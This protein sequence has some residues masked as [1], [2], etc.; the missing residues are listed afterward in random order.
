MYPQ[1]PVPPSRHSP[2]ASLACASPAARAHPG[3]PSSEVMGVR[4]R[5]PRSPL[6]GQRARGAP[7]VGGAQEKL[8]IRPTLP[9]GVGG[10]EPAHRACWSDRSWGAPPQDAP[11]LLRGK[12]GKRG[13]SLLS[14]C[15]WACFSMCP[16]PARGQQGGGA[17]LLTFLARAQS[18]APRR[19]VLCRRASVALFLTVFSFTAW[20]CSARHC[21]G[22]G[23]EG[24]EMLLPAPTRG[25]QASLPSSAYLDGS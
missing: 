13:R 23:R 22:G 2:R 12:S 21:S 20:I 7:A 16:S 18:W 3:Y 4:R 1:P 15:V 5:G 19:M 14:P 17:G 9:S 6:H 24:T 25:P 8:P 11:W 10:G